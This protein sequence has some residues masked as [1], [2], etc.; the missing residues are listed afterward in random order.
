MSIF[1]HPTINNS[2][3]F[4]SDENES[5]NFFPSIFKEGDV[6]HVIISLSN[7]GIILFIIQFSK[8]LKF[9]I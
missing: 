9:Y 4:Y 1:I 5:M 3:T 8:F 7:H 2:T 6:K